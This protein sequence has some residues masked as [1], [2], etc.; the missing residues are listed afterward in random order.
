LNKE[1]GS[2]KNSLTWTSIRGIKISQRRVK[3]GWRNFIN[4]FHFNKP[5]LLKPKMRLFKFVVTYFT[6]LKRWLY[7]P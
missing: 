4:H 7:L 3:V 1:K 6:P 5:T 2:L